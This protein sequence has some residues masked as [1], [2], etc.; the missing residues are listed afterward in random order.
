MVF[1]L[2]IGL[3]S[4]FFTSIFDG[5]MGGNLIKLGS[6]VFLSPISYFFGREFQRREATQKNVDDKTGQILEDTRTLREHTQNGDALDEIEDIEEKAK[7]L[8]EDE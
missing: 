3:I 4:V 6:L 7:R 8:R 5:D 2:L 1:A